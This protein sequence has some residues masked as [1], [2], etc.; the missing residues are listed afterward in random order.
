MEL[1][2]LIETAATEAGFLDD[3]LVLLERESVELGNID[4]NGMDVSNQAKELLIRKIS[5]HSPSLQQAVSACSVRE[6]LPSSTSL[7]ALAEHFSKKGNKEL[8]LIQ[9]Q[10][11]KTADK[12]KQAAAL[13][14]EVAERFAAMV[15][16][17]LGLI[18]RLVN[19]SNVYGASGGYQQQRTSAV[20]I[21][22]EA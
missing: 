3:L 9:K 16:T 18:T 19:Q 10:M 14:Q 4:I 2:K 22:R 8:L 17:S 12:I 13:N 5:G 20:M 15:T 7:V 6:G 1:K 21:N 11:S